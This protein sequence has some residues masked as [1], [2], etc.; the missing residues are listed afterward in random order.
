MQRPRS[1][2][3]ILSAA[4]AGGGWLGAAKRN[5]KY[6]LP[7]QM[8]FEKFSPSPKDS[9]SNNRRP[10]RCSADPMPNRPAFRDKH[11]LLRQGAKLQGWSSPLAIGWK[12]KTP[13]AEAA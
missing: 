7:N 1:L 9:I 12:S 3:I 11:P 8:R 5:T 10:T 2:A 4:V 6:V 13:V